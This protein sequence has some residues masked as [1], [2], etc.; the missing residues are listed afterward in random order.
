MNSLIEDARKDFIISFGS[1][2][3]EEP[4]EDLKELGIL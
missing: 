4:V 1:C 3:F 2:S